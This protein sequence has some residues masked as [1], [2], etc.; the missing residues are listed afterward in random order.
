MV[1]AAVAE[2]FTMAGSMLRSAGVWAAA[3]VASSNPRARSHAI[4]MV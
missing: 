1:T 2:P 3:R 4:G